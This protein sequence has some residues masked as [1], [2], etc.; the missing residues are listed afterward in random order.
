MLAI[1]LV[2]HFICCRRAVTYVECSL[3]TI[4]FIETVGIDT[5]T[6][7]FDIATKNNEFTSNSI[8]LQ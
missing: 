1:H 6:S 3:P 8:V 2:H 5:V 7:Q 4:I